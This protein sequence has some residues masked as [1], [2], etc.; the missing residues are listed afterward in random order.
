MDVKEVDVTSSVMQQNEG[1]S[2]P[3]GLVDVYGDEE[4]IGNAFGLNYIFRKYL[5]DYKHSEH[6]EAMV[7]RTTCCGCRQKPSNPYL[8]SCLHIYCHSC[9]LETSHYAARRGY[10]QVRCSEC[11]TAYTST[12]RLEDTTGKPLSSSESD[13]GTG[14]KGKK[15]DPTMN[16]IEAPGPVLPSA[17]SVAVK[18]AIL[19]FVEED[20]HQKII[21]YTQWNPMVR[22]LE[23]V[24]RSEGWQCRKYTGNMSVESKDRAVH[25]FSNLKDVNILIAGLK[26]GG[27]GLNL[28]AAQRV[29]LIDPWWNKAIEQQAFCRV[30]RIG[31]Q[32]TTSLTRF[33]CRNTIDEAM[34]QVKERKQIEIDE[35]MNN[36][37][38]REKLTV[39]DLMRL[40]G[41][42]EED[43][44]GRPFIFAD[45]RS[46][47]GIPRADGDDDNEFGFMNTDE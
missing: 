7:E 31:Q 35:L 29:L 27:L 38:L 4:N 9:L 36:S 17:K 33:V 40:F 20:P 5:D 43:E 15:K 11:G 26:C 19:N 2:F 34:M 23:K 39:E 18:A 32:K 6:W 44:E 46:D 28:T 24:C 30:F 1:E 12:E 3:T 10:D 16:W 21:I 25:E 22:I 37:K 47:D 13:E 45:A 42:V 14:R 8:T 41:K